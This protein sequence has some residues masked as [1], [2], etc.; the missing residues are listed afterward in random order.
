[1]QMKLFLICS[2]IF[3]SVGLGMIIGNIIPTFKIFELGMGL[4]LLGVVTGMI[5]AIIENKIEEVKNEEV[6][7]LRIIPLN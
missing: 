3:M 4:L 5:G 6:K 2:L 7:R 1:M